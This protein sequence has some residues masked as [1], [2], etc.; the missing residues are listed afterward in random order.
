MSCC[1]GCHGIGYQCCTPQPE[2][3]GDGVALAFHYGLLGEGSSAWEGRGELVGVPVWATSPGHILTLERGENT[4][5]HE[6]DS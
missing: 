1:D 4:I 5:P 3:G 2:V 6:A